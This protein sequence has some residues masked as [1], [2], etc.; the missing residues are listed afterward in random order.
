M[1]GDGRET[2]HFDAID[3]CGVPNVTSGVV[4]IVP[5]CWLAPHTVI[6]SEA[7]FHINNSQLCISIFSKLVERYASCFW[8]NKIHVKINMKDFTTGLT[9]KR[10]KK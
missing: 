5:N 7:L 9:V 6:V 8:H 4:I 1:S 3:I 10:Q 2:D